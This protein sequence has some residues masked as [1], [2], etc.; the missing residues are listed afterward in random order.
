[1]HLSNVKRIIGAVI[2]C[3]AAVFS[4]GQDPHFSQFFSSPLTLNPA[5]T[6]KF[7]GS[8]RVAGNYRNQWPAFNNV[9]STATVSVDFPMFQKSLPEKDIFGLGILALTDKEGQGLVSSNYLGISAAYHKALTDEG[10][11]QLS[12]GFQAVY[13]MKKIDLTK[14]VFEDQLSPTGFDL[15]K[16]SSDLS[17]IKKANIQYLDM[18]AGVL[19]TSST[20]PTNNLYFGASLYHIN[21]PNES[22]TGGDWNTATRATLSAG[23]FFPLSEIITIHT[24]ALYQ[25]QAKATEFT[26]GGA[27]SATIGNPNVEDQ[28]PTSVYLGSWLRLKDALIPYVGLE[29]QGFRIGATYDINTSS[30]KTGSQSRGGMEV[31]LIYIRPSQESKGIPCP[32][33]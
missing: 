13:G 21:K 18:N 3:F 15:Q 23:G 25:Q 29:F 6:A 12:A 2:F 14:L 27:L 20:A 17:N 28:Q 10:Y 26:I 24:S 1:M 19:F 11:Q 31:S 16:G 9:Y 22:F 8:L 33:F 7:D 32:K 5:F 30:L 4:Y